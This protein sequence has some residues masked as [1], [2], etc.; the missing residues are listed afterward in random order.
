METIKIPEILLPANADKM[1]A[2]AVNAC[3][4]YTSDA[5]YW[6]NVEKLTAGQPSAYNLIF[7]EIYL[8]DKPEERI[9]R[10]NKTMRQYLSGAIFKKVSGG[11][12]LVERKT[13]SGTRTGIVLAIDLEDY[14]F[15][16]GTKAL[17][18]ST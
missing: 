13:Q 11:F 17:I 5:E 9:A 4:Q 6:K 1:E 14:S 8:K 7:P 3:D 2:W 16:A 10:I 15:E 12:I 18:R